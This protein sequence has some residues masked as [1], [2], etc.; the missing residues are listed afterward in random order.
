MG[1]R[2]VVGYFAGFRP[3]SY[4][5]H[6]L[7]WTFIVN[8]DILAEITGALGLCPLSCILKNTFRNVDLSVLV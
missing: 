7:A 4:H 1:L 8:T 2:K 6:T 5:A 3:R